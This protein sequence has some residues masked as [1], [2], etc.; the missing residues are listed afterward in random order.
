MCPWFLKIVDVNSCCD[1]ATQVFER[2]LNRD[3][4][5]G[6]GGQVTFKKGTAFLYFR[7]F[8]KKLVSFNRLPIFPCNGLVTV[9]SFCFFK[10]NKIVTSYHKK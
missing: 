7:Y 6:S 2:K 3:R 10:S 4:D 9:T 8:Q 5:K 1:L